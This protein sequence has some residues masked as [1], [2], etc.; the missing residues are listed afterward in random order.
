MPLPPPAGRADSYLRPGKPEQARDCLRQAASHRHRR[1]ARFAEVFLFSGIRREAALMANRPSTNPTLRRHAGTPQGGCIS[2]LLANIALHG[3]ENDLIK[4]CQ[5]MTDRE[6][7][8]VR[9]ADDFVVIHKDKAIIE[10]CQQFTTG[11]LKQM[12]LEPKPSKTRVTRVCS[13]PCCW[14]GPSAVTRRRGNI[15]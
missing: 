2:P 9:Y 15:G 13:F 8:M 12:G 6:P 1:E 10:E 14:H 11:W 3:M 5:T 4:H 7:R